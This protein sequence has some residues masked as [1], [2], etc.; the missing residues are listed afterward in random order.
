MTVNSRTADSGPVRYGGGGDDL[1][2]PLLKQAKIISASDT[3]IRQSNSVFISQNILLIDP[4]GNQEKN[5]YLGL[6]ET[7][8]EHVKLPSVKRNTFE[9]T[10]ITKTIKILPESHIAI[11]IH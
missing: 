10:G 11:V 3:I 1:P 9:G 7:L 6:E 8:E 5:A 2:D 4:I